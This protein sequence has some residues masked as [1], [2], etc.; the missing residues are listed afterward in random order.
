MSRKEGVKKIKIKLKYSLTPL[1]SL[2][3]FFLNVSPLLYLYYSIYTHIHTCVNHAYIYL[4]LFKC[5]LLPTL[6]Y[7]S[8]NAIILIYWAHLLGQY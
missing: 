7:N 3:L 4:V 2:L 6:V 8:E 5:V 1:F